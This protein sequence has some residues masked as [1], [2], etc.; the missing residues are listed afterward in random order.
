MTASRELLT[1]LEPEQ[2]AG[3][4]G[5]FEPGSRFRVEDVEFRCGTSAQPS[6]RGRFSIRK[7]RALVEEYLDL[8]D[9]FPNA[10]IVEL[11]VG[12]GGALPWPRW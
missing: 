10:N 9:D 3:T 8:L 4:S 11:G 12:D 7:H 1:W 5:W 6:Q 2:D